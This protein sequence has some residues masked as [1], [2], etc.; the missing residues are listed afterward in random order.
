[1]LEAIQGTQDQSLRPVVP[2][3]FHA[4]FTSE[5]TY[6]ETQSDLNASPE[7][8]HWSLSGTGRHTVPVLPTP[9]RGL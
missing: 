3:N 1:M 4:F 9:S 7:G 5:G 8:V 2:S 6:R